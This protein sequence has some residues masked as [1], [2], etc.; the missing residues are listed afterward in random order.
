M[1]SVEYDID[2]TYEFFDAPKEVDFLELVKE[3]GDNGSDRWF[4][5]LS[6]LL[7]LTTHPHADEQKRMQNGDMDTEA[8]IR[9]EMEDDDRQDQMMSTLYPESVHSN[10]YFNQTMGLSEAPS[11]LSDDHRELDETTYSTKHQ[12]VRHL[13]KPIT[14]K[15]HTS[16]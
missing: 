8:F 6:N 7:L 12:R 15:F 13:T 9:Q 14:P 5:G 10:A 4:G 2:P 3:Q 1:A 16:R 11:D